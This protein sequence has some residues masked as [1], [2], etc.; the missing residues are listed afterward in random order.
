MKNKTIK[1]LSIIIIFCVS[2]LVVSAKSRNDAAM[3]D[4]NNSSK[5]EKM[6]IAVLDFEA[7]GVS[8]PVAANVSDLVRNEMIN[9]GRYIVIERSQMGA[10]L[11]E[12]GLQNSGCTDVSCAVQIGKFLSARKML[13]GTVMKI[14]TKIVINGRIIDVEK[15][16][17]EYSEKSKAYSEENIVDAA[18]EFSRNLIAR[19]EGKTS[20]A[21]TPQPQNK[22]SD[23]NNSPASERVNQRRR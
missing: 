17:A 8:K 2:A 16:V 11:K 21:V 13:V 15:A 12:Q 6:S 1:I 23:V 9:C 3:T 14:G 5:T 19:I 20:P 22:E 4:K 7:R 18:E 10:I